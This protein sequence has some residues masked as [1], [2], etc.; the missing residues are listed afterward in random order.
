MAEWGVRLKLERLR[1]R[2]VATRTLQFPGFASNKL[3]GIIG[4]RLWAR[5]DDAYNTFFAPVATHGPSGLTDPPRPFVLRSQHLDGATILEGAHFHFDL[6][7]FDLRGQWPE[8]LQESLAEVGTARLQHV[9]RE[10]INVPLDGSDPE[11]TARVRFLTPTEL[12][13][14]GKLI[15]EPTFAVLAGRIRDRIST[16]MQRYGNGPLN[17]DF[18]ALSERATRV[19]MTR[20]ELTQIKAARRS[21]RT[22]QMHP[23]GGFIGEVDYEGDLTGFVPLLKAAEWT[24]V[25]RQTSWGK[26]AI[27]LHPGG[28]L[29]RRS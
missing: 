14:N 10:D 6:H 26:G 3:R 29:I 8:V 22:G 16:L 12:K 17:I 18:E 1:F 9:E 7:L 13:A 24:G 2:Y 25:G 23:L 20:C 4:K 11:T 21:G 5:D 15:E 19:R 28:K 27:S